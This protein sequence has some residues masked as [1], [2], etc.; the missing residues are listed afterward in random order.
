[1]AVGANP[2]RHVALDLLADAFAPGLFI[3]SIKVGNDT[4]KVGGIGARVP[5]LGCVAN[6][7]RFGCAVQDLL[8]LLIR[9]VTPGRMQAEVVLFRQ[10]LQDRGMPLAAIDNL[11]PRGDSSLEQAQ[12]GMCHD[13]FCI[14]L[15]LSTK[16]CTGRACSMRTVE[17]KGTWSN[18]RQA[19]AAVDTGELL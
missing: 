5:M 4:L 6:G 12:L 2:R 11:N 19:D 15:L 10:C 3:A 14:D 13:Q 17:A 8:A 7:Q 1:M 9:Q 18:L 16:A